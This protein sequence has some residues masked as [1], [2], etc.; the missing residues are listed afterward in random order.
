[1][2]ASHPILFYFLFL[3]PQ[4]YNRDNLAQVDSIL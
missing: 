1:V 3:S 2:A 4:G